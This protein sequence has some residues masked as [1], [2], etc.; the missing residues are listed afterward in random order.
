M[1]PCITRVLPGGL[2]GG[3]GEQNEC[4]QMFQKRCFFGLRH[5]EGWVLGLT[6]HSSEELQILLG[7][8]R[9]GRGPN[10]QSHI[11]KVSTNDE[12]C[13]ISVSEV[14]FLTDFKQFSK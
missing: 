10:R 3:S 5:Q 2:H 12:K 1:I 8:Y 13:V 14:I 11:Q 9:C 7:S 4:F 6:L